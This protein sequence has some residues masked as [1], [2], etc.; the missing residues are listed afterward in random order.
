MPQTVAP[1]TAFA[2]PP[3]AT[4]S[5]PGARRQPAAAPALPGPAPTPPWRTSVARDVAVADA[6]T[7][8]ALEAAGALWH[9]MVRQSDRSR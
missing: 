7:A 1:T 8:E 2:A 9:V 4:R 3:V 6:D 5:R